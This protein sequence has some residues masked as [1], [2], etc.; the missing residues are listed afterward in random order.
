MTL[1]L[2][3]FVL[4][5]GREYGLGGIFALFID[6]PLYAG[7]EILSPLRRQPLFDGLQLGLVFQLLFGKLVVDYC[8]RGLSDGLL[9]IVADWHPDLKSVVHER[10]PS[11]IS[12]FEVYTP[13]HTT[14]PDF[15]SI[16]IVFELK[17]QQFHIPQVFPK[18]FGIGSYLEVLLASFLHP[19]IE[20]CAPDGKSH[21]DGQDGHL[22]KAKAVEFNQ[23]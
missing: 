3:T 12:L 5:F 13:I 16:S 7:I 11:L 19:A 8:N 1:I 9:A 10:T 6:D 4:P 14:C 18:H 2:I 17:P 20:L 21:N 23:Q 15:F 22:Q